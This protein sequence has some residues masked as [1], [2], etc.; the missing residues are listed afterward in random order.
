[1]KSAIASLA[2]AIL[3]SACVT[4]GGGAGSD[5]NYDSAN[6]K[7][8]SVK[9][10]TRGVEVTVNESV[11]FDIGKSELKAASNDLIDRVATIL[12]DRSKKDILIEGHT[13]STGG[14]Q[15]NQRLS[16]QRAEAVK[17]ALVKRGVAAKRMKTV[18]QG[19]NKP[20]ADNASPEGR[21]QNRR[22]QVVLLGETTDNIGGEN[23]VGYLEGAIARLKD[24]GSAVL[25][26]FRK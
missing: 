13:D 20:V 2:S 14:A 9:Q 23:A 11:F 16:E 1:M 10:T 17:G 4:T 22:T 8:V 5:P 21:Q 19:M 24:L 15:A 25:D 18:G 6:R 7:N 26:A 3:L 12:K